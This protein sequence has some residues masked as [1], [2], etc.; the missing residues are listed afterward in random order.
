[1]S[2]AIG[3]ALVA[4]LLAS[5]GSSP[6]PREYERLPADETEGGEARRTVER[7]PLRDAPR[8][9]AQPSSSPIVTIRVAFEAGSAADEPGREGATMLAARLMAEGGAGALS[10]AEQSERLYPMA[11]RIETHVGRDQTVFIGQVHRDHLEAFYELFRDVLLR[12]RMEEA[13]FERVRAQVRTALAIDLRQ[14]RDEQLGK[15]ALQAF[16]YAD[17]PYGHPALGT[18]AGLDRLRLD[19]VRAH[20]SRVFCA[21]RA[22]VGV[23]GAFPE[24]FA[25][26]V[27]RDVGTL[28]SDACV[29]RAVL[30]EVGSIDAPRVVIVDKPAAEAVAVSMGSPIEVRRDHPDYPAMVL[31]AAWLGQHR[32]FVGRLMQQIRG[33]RGLNYGDYAYAEHFTQDGS[34]TFPIPNDARRQQYFSIW[35]RPLRPSDAHFA[36]RLAIRELARLVEHGLDQ[37]ELDRIRGF[38]TSYI[39][40]YL[41]TPSRRLGFAMDDAFYGVEGDYLERLRA[42]WTALSVDEVNAAIRRHLD[43]ARLR[44][45]IVSGDAEE[46]ATALASDAESPITYRTS[47][48]ETVL[49]DDREIV[50]YP[51]RIPRERIEI[52]PL[53]SLF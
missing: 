26:R 35:L 19:D 40:L 13:D 16:V 36:I 20:R 45:A 14:A 10:Y 7:E 43:P 38:V 1:M 27:A 29:G 39:A 22:M 42:A 4:A 52:V 49:E 41:Q 24:G 48:P 8:V 21:G 5:C 28:S 37:A 2:R 6:A 33:V 30:P 18:V 17:H 25:A 11:A 32:Q 53:D 44:I 12:P 23:A 9:I 51:L 31:V 50:R 3:T 34:S 47:V 46:L 15:E